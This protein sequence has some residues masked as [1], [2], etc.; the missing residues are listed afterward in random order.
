[1]SLPEWYKDWID[2]VSNIVSFVYP[3]DGY[4]KNQY[5]Q[6]LKKNGI[7]ESDY[8]AEACD[9]GTFIHL[10][11]EN[12]IRNIE[13]DKEHYLYNE[14]KNEIEYGL[15]CLSLMRIVWWNHKLMTEVVIRDKYDR[16]QWT[17]DLVRIDEK[18]KKVW[19]YDWKTWWIAKKK[20]NLP[21]AHKKPYDKIKKVGLQLSLYAEYYRQKG[22]SIE[23]LSVLRLH[24]SGYYEY[25]TKIYSMKEIDKILLD[26]SWKTK[27]W[28]LINNISDMIIELR[29]PTEQ[30]GY[31]NV[32][33]DMY[34]EE[35]GKTVETLIDEWINA[36]KYV[37]EW[38]RK[39]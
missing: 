1:M 20:F 18:N 31:V 16:Y 30:Y 12:A 26:Y 21:N 34:K 23:W 22:Y 8:M 7:D 24:E 6:W 35:S 2:R 9:V 25:E 33:I 15:E 3:F 14:H 10:Q 5:L 29:K 27:E 37:V 17:I 28:I 13:L 32:T 19:I 4:T 39:S 38:K 11:M 36:I